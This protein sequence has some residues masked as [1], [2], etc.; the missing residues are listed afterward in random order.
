MLTKEEYEALEAAVDATYDGTLE[1]VPK[2]DLA[3][4]ALFKILTD[5]GLEPFVEE[6]DRALEHKFPLGDKHDTSPNASESYR[7]QMND[8]GRGNLLR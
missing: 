1:R 4:K 2:E 8:A 7:D 5:F 3:R 6:T